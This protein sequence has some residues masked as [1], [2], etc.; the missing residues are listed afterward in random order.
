VIWRRISHPNVVPF[1]G[2]SEAPAPLSMVSEWMPNGNV[3]D[4]VVKNPEISRLQL[5]RRVYVHWTRA[6]TTLVAR[7]QS[8]SEVFAHLRHHTWRFERGA[9]LCFF[10]RSISADSNLTTYHRITS[11]LISQVVPGSMI[12]GSLVSP[13][14]TAPR[15]PRLDLRDPTDG[16]H[17]SSTGSTTKECLVFARADR[18]HLLWGWSLLR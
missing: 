4:Y 10:L 5:V 15:H 8:W 17:P 12:S 13:V 7:H 9:R 11:S 2:V 6:D 1:I 18:T 3:R 16:W 14:S